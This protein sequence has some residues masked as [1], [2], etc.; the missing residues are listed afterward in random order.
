MAR[1]LFINLTF[2]LGKLGVR[3]RFFLV[4]GGFLA[5]LWNEEEKGRQGEE[6]GYFPRMSCRWIGGGSGGVD[7]LPTLLVCSCLMR[8]GIID[9]LFILPDF[10]CLVNIS[11][12]MWRVVLMG[13]RSVSR[14]MVCEI[15]CV[16]SSATRSHLSHKPTEV[17]GFLRRQ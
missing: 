17:M 9:E 16:A 15:R 5:F 13:N 7:T 3:G 11:I 6:I 2:D 8:G 1:N 14:G 10:R 4:D 12:R